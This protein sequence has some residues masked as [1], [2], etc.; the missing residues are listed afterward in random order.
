VLKY[1]K[2]SRNRS[3]LKDWLLL[4]KVYFQVYFLLC[5]KKHEIPPINKIA[6]T[7]GKTIAKINVVFELF[8]GFFEGV[9]VALDEGVKF[10]IGDT[11][12]IFETLGEADLV[13]L[14]DIEGVKLGL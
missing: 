1:W 11:F 14:F 3:L 5:I 4:R 6:A 2:K 10:G 7:I 12:P 8:E 13:G 9:K